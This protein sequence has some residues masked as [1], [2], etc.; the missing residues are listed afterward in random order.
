M[1]QVVAVV[2]CNLKQN[3]C[4]FAT[5]IFEQVFFCILILILRNEQANVPSHL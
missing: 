5:A 1:L 4:K 3:S 2:L